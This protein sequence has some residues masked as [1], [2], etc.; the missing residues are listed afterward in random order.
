M[1]AVGDTVNNFSTP[2]QSHARART[3]AACDIFV[4]DIIRRHI[5]TNWGDIPIQNT[6]LTSLTD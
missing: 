3:V 4:Q 6:F 1:E 5:A 2:G